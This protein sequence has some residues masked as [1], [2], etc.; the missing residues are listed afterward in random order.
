MKRFLTTLAVLTVMVC[1]FAGSAQAFID[2]DAFFRCTYATDQ[3]SY[4]GWGS[5]DAR[6]C[7]DG[8][9]TTADYRSVPAWHWSNGAWHRANIGENT[10]VYIYPFGSGW[11]W[12]WAKDTG[13]L[14][15]QSKYAKINAEIL[16]GFGNCDAGPC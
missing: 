1:A 16:V 2:N 8:M 11:S 3:P 5:I 14:A 12:V 10:R 15:V 6:A 4:K 13:W 9:A 7:A